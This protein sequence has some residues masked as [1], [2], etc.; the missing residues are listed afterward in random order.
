MSLSLDT[1]TNVAPASRLPSWLLAAI[2]LPL[3]VP[4]VV[5]VVREWQLA[6]HPVQGQVLVD[7]RP[8][9]AA[10]VTAH[11]LTPDSSPVPIA[12]ATTDRHGRFA[13]RALGLFDGVGA[14]DYALTVAWRPQVVLGESLVPGPNQLPVSYGVPETTPLR[15]TVTP[16]TNQLPTWS[17][18]R[19]RCDSE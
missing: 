12:W 10:E 8:A 7:A 6:R 11:R 18:A 3:S 13:L 19:C 16:G 1:S 14:G 2:V 15:W 17:L 5:S 9:L 4:P